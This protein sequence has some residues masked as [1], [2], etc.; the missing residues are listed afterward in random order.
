MSVRYIPYKSKLS[1]LIRAAGGKSV[2]EAV[3]AADA[4]VLTIEAAGLAVLDR[5]TEEIRGLV[6]G[7]REAATLGRLY[8]AA[9][10]IGGLAGQFG[11]PD[12][13]G[14]AYS[15]CELID[16]ADGVWPARTSVQVHVDALRLLRLGEAAPAEE[17]ERVLAGL[18]DV[19]RRASKAA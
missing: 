15:L 16:Q 4:N 5:K 13:T 7:E 6:A 14:A 17:R 18:R 10:E 11:L 8:Q 3:K 19:V 12:L 1:K 9:D 2:S